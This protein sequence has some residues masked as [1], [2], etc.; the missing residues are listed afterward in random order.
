[1]FNL[2]GVIWALKVA[3][4]AIKTCSLLLALA[5]KEN[6]WLSNL[7]QNIQKVKADKKLL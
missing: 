2:I 3:I 5:T 1:M 4:V 6:I 7:K